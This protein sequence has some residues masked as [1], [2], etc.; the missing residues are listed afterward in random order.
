[1][2]KILNSALLVVT[3]LFISISNVKAEGV[4]SVNYISKDIVTEGNTI[5]VDININNV[6]AST[7][8]KMYSL[9][10]YIEFDQEY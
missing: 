1:M 9:G 10:G 3:L 4:I 7:D 2:K 6:S 8:G 5:S